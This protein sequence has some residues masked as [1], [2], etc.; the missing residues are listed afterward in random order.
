MVRCIIILGCVP[1]VLTSDPHL[2]GN[3]ALSRALGDFDFKQNKELPAE[4]QVVTGKIIQYMI[5]L[6]AF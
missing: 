2:S 4:E 3:L 6:F 1:V 5:H